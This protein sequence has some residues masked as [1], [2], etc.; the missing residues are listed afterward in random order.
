VALNATPDAGPHPVRHLAHTLVQIALDDNDEMLLINKFNVDGAD[1][2]EVLG[3]DGDGGDNDEDDYNGEG[4]STCNDLE[5]TITNEEDEEDSDDED[6]DDE[7]NGANP[8][9][10][11]RAF[12]TRVRVD[13]AKRAEGNWRAGG[14]R[15]QRA[16]VKAWEVC[17]LFAKLEF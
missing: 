1:A 10:S 2:E 12:Q 16:M 4:P 5:E 11:F 9:Q 17:Y 13:A 14:L 6:S 15:T 7:G 3:Y 8:R